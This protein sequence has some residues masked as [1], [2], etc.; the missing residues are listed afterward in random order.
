MF[1]EATTGPGGSAA[2][3]ARFKVREGMHGARYGEVLLVTGHLNRIE[4]TVYNTLGLNDCPDDLWRTLDPAAIKRTYRAR[5]AILNGPRY[6]LMDK[7]AIADPGQEIVDFGGLQMQPL[8]TVP[9]SPAA[10]LGG[11]RREPYR[12]RVVQRTTVYVYDRGREVYEL[13]APDGAVYVMQSYS[14]AVDS[15]LTEARLPLLGERLRLPPG[16]RYQVRQLEQE[17][18]LT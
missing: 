8:A 9:L 16:W 5:A 10:L 3:A 4:A 6:F 15:T 7:V 14:L 1:D 11:L 2:N 17:L 12:E 13:V 18:A